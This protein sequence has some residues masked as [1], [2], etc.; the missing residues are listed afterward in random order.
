MRLMNEPRKKEKHMPVSL[1]YKPLFFIKAVLCLFILADFPVN[2]ASYSTDQRGDGDRFGLDIITSQPS[3]KGSD[4]K[5]AKEQ[6][7]FE[8]LVEEVL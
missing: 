7:R 4:Q 2:A 5:K 1:K 3:S 6:A 8:T